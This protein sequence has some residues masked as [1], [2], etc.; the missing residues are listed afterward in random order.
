MKNVLRLLVF[1]ALVTVFALPSY[2]QDAAAAQTPAAGPCTTESE[3]KAAL[4]QKFLASYKG[5]P[6]QQKAAS[7]T[8]KEYLTRF[9][10]CP[11]EGD[12]KIATFIQNWNNRYAKATD[13]FN[14]T[15][16]AN[17][18]TAEAFNVCG[19]L[20]SANPDNLTYRLAMVGAGIKS[21]ANKNNSLNAK[22]A[23]EARTALQMIESGKTTDKW[24]PFN[25]QQEAQT[26]LRYWIAAWSLEANP[27]EASTQLLKVAQSG[28]NLAKEPAT[29][30][31]LAT[32]YYNGELKPRVDEYKAKCEGKEATTECDA[33]LHK[34]NVVL[35][36]V[37]DSYARAI[38]LSNANPTKYGATATTLRPILT[39]L[40]KQRHE[41]QETGL[42]ELIA[43]VLSKPVPLPSQDPAFTPPT[44]AANGTTGNG[45]TAT[46]AGAATST[47][48]AAGTPAAKPTA[49]PTP[50][51]AA[52]PAQKP[53][54]S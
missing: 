50:K 21:S 52:T 38:A 36:R 40:Y 4:Y 5:T 49:T 27:A 34:I 8:G 25:N 17:D 24:A 7:D 30:Q 9:G 44:P 12:K 54:R 33:L 35:D 6:E 2:A 46:P 16:A 48:P 3:A 14:C 15:K 42:N 20:A 10:N 22:A 37:I 41:G 19:R 45:M 31:L 18:N 26:M 1:A 29:F 23:A 13:D 51:P 28:D 32:S 43:G 47:T 39:N 53:P 11:D